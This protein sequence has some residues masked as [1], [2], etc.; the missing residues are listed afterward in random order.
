M[1]ISSVSF[2]LLKG[3]EQSNEKKKIDKFSEFCRLSRV[4]ETLFLQNDIADHFNCIFPM[5]WAT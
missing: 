5:L 2:L 3:L 4:M 1:T